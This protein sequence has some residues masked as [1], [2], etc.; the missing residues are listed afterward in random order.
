MPCLRKTT[1]I[2]LTCVV[3][4]LSTG[5]L[6]NSDGDRIVRRSE[7]RRDISF[8]TEEGLVRFQKAVRERSGYNERYLGRSSF[9]IP[10]LISADRKRILSENAWYN[11]QVTATD[12]NGDGELSDAEVEGY[13]G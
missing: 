9:A 3:N 7:A 5:C 6:I 12:V 10:F 1:L 4:P 8:E 2:C 13:L 11:D